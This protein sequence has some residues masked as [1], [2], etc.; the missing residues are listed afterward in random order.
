MT[1]EVKLDTRALESLIRAAPEQLDAAVRATAFGVQA[2]AQDLSPYETGANRASIYAKT[3]KG[4]S[5]TPGD[6]GDILPDVG[7]GEAVIG[8][9]MTYSAFLEYGTSRMGARPYLTPAAEQAQR[10]F[11]ANVKLVIP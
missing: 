7:I 11:A 4:I 8:P 2:I 5:G 10:L 3:S 1:I 6:L 9:S